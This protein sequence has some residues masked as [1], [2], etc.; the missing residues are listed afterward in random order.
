MNGNLD[1]SYLVTLYEEKTSNIIEINTNEFEKICRTCL[2]NSDIYH[3]KDLKHGNIFIPSLL[4]A[5]T[6][7]EV[8]STYKNYTGIAHL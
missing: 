1:L 3:F 5:Y 4:K 7:L 2:S 6:S 8:K